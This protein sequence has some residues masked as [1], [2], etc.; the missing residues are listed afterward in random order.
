MKRTRTAI[1]YLKSRNLQGLVPVIQTAASYFSKPARGVWFSVACDTLPEW[2]LH[3]AISSD[4][5]VQSPSL[6][7]IQAARVSRQRP[8]YVTLTTL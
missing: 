8:E 3:M 6:K 2:Q 1:K 4:A 5:S 7:L